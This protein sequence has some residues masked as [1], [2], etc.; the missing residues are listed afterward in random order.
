MIKIRCSQCDKKVGVPDESAGKR[1]KCPQ[2]EAVNEIPLQTSTGAPEGEGEGG[3]D[4]LPGSLTMLSECET[5]SEWIEPPKRTGGQAVLAGLGLI[6]RVPSY[7]WLLGVLVIVLIYASTFLLQSTE[8]TW[9]ADHREAIVSLEARARS[10]AEAGQMKAAGETYKE[11]IAMVGER[12]IRDL[13]LAGVVDRAEQERRTISRI[14]KVKAG[15]KF[16]NEAKVR[17][18]AKLAKGDATARG[19][20][21]KSAILIYDEAVAMVDESPHIIDEL[22]A[23]RR[24]AERGKVRARAKIT[25]LAEKDRADRLRRAKVLEGA[26]KSVGGPVGY[27]GAFLDARRALRKGF[28]MDTLTAAAY[29]KM[30]RSLRTRQSSTV[31]QPIFQAG[32]DPP[33]AIARDGVMRTR[34]LA[35]LCKGIIALYDMARRLAGGIAGDQFGGKMPDAKALLAT[36]LDRITALTAETERIYGRLKGFVDGKSDAI[37]ES[38]AA[39]VAQMRKEQEALGDGITNLD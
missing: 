1:V 35:D 29:E 12:E 21:Y 8:D 18:E 30:V 9:E 33:S 7:V 11:L 19:G 5:S 6:R 15:R 38:S 14:L 23:L 24:E 4:V 32:Y 28:K 10:Q 27:V 20:Q 37:P 16:Y 26:R 34:E 22:A 13:H 17:I 25:E 2:C 36:I 3:T 31:D 39:V